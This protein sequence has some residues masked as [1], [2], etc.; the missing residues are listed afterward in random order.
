MGYRVH[1]QNL[2][3]MG[4]AGHRMFVMRENHDGSGD[5]L[6]KITVQH[7]GPHENIPESEAFLD[8]SS[9]PGWRVRDFLQAMSDAAWELGIKPK[10]IEDNS[11]EL[12]ATKF[13]LEDMRTLVLKK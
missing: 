2:A 11:N 3:M 8:D 1:L 10:Q 9:M 13:H 6:H 5:V 7:H 4:L 12:K